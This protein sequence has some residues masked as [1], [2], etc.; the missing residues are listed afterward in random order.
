MSEEVSE[1]ASP[2]IVD[3]HGHKINTE[4]IPLSRFINQETGEPI[5]DE[6]WDEQQRRLAE[7]VVPDDQIIFDDETDASQHTEE[8]S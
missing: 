7:D 2:A 4:E 8:Q 3:F 6:E 5:T 1:G